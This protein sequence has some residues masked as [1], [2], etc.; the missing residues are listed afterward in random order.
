MSDKL[1]GQFLGDLRGE[2]ARVRICELVELLVHRRE[3]VRMRMSQ[4]GD[5]RA[6]RRIDVL[7]AR[8]VTDGDAPPDR[9]EGVGMA[10]LAMKDM[11]HAGGCRS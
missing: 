11:G 3:H 9:G 5:G 10:G 6:A 1:V 7:L 4:T 2:E 8:A